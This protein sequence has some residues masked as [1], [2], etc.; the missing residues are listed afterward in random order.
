MSSYISHTQ[1]YPATAIASFFIRRGVTP[2]KVQKLLYYSNV[3]HYVKHGKLLFHD[4]IKAWIYGPVVP[5]V[6][7]ELKYFRRNDKINTSVADRISPISDLHFDYATHDTLNGV[8]NA[9]GHLSG[10]QLVDLTHREKPWCDAR[11]G[12]GPKDNGYSVVE[13]NDYTTSEFQLDF[14]GEI[15]VIEG[16]RTALGS[17]SNF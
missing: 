17:F 8:W 7:Q 15:P 1:S 2:L 10:S 16:D 12:L 6:W 4:S 13:I 9:Y 5:G 11:I 14:N 3:W